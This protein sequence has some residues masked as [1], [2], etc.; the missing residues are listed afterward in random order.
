[1]V[2]S[3]RFCQNCGHNC[4]CGKNCEKDYGELKKT[5]CCTHC[6]CEKHDDSWEDTVKYDNI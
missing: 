1:M 5:V 3:Q 4:H 2:N 6:R